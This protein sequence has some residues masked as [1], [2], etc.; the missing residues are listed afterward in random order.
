MTNVKVQSIYLIV[1]DFGAS[2]RFYR[3]LLGRKETVVMDWGP[4]GH[5]GAFF[6]ID[7]GITFIVSFEG[8]H[9]ALAGRQRM[10]FELERDD[11]AAIEND[12]RSEGFQCARGVHTTEAGSRAITALDPDG[13]EVRIGT[14]WSL[15]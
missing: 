6:E 4:P 3:T 15:P 14:R 8:Q 9:P 5:Q 2:V 13:N 1:G 12:L 10:W 7:G 11:P